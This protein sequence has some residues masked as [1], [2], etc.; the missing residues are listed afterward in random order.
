MG[1][2]P[3][4]STAMSSTDMKAVVVSLA[5]GASVCFPV[6]A[7]RLKPPQQPQASRFAWPDG[8]RAAVSLTFDDARPSQLDQGLAVFAETGL[9][10]SFYLT[11]SNLGGRAADWKKAAAAGHE[12][13]NHTVNHPCSG[14]FSWSRAHALEDFT[15]D[16]MREE[17]TAATREIERLTGVR[18]VTFAYPCGQTFVGRGRAVTSYVPLVEELFVAGRLWLSEAPNDPAYVDLSQLFGYPMD[19]VDFSALEPVLRDTIDRGQWL[20]LAGHDTGS[21]PGKQVTRL[22][23]IRALARYLQERRDVWVD[24]VGNVA[25]YVRRARS[26]E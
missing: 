2:L 21:V 15:L 25:A 12:L 1:G 23:T 20:V 3:V 9:K 16:R 26:R 22:E 13:G 24:T 4:I 18:P 7:V 6:R 10:V 19:D 11:A 14:N 5:I 8:K 17:L